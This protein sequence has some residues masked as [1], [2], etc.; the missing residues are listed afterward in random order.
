MHNNVD[1][2]QGS[3]AVAPELS[4]CSKRAIKAAELLRD[5]GKIRCEFGIDYDDVMIML[6]CGSINFTQ[7]KFSISYIQPANIS[8]IVDYLSTPRETVRR[9]LLVLEENQLV[10]RLAHGYLIKDIKTWYSLIGNY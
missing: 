5:F 2:R 10:I 8:S 9:R 3:P 4:D 1:V 6:A 7:R